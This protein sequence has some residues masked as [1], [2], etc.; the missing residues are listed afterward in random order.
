MD[1]FA[2][3]CGFDPQGEEMTFI[4]APEPKAPVTQGWLRVSQRK[5]DPQRSTGHLAYYP[6]DE[7]QP[8][9]PGQIYEVDLEIWPLGLAL[10]RGSCLTLTLQGKDFERLGATGPMRGVAWFTHDDPV[11]RLPELFAGINTIHTGGQHQSYLL[12]PIL[13]GR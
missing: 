9:E 8:L 13:P 7:R 4:A 2:T 11:D 5:L 12:L 3:V 1:I 10:P 6:H